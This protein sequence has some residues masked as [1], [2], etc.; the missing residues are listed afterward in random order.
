MFMFATDSILALAAIAGLCAAIL[1]AKPSLVAWLIF[2]SVARWV[3]APIL[4]SLAQ[5]TLAFLL[6]HWGLLIVLMILAPIVAL[7][8][9]AR[10]FESL[11]KLFLGPAAG[12]RAAGH[13]FGTWGVR[14]T[15]WILGRRRGRPIPDWAD[16][17]EG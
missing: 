5:P 10:V 3:I 15:D 6:Q 12:G 4:V 7:A 9:A 1:G 16:E 13:M 17:D 8:M 2:P 11:L 14:F